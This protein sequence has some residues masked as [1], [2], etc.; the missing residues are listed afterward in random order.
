MAPKRK[1]QKTA[2]NRWANSGGFVRDEGRALSVANN[3]EEIQEAD[4]NE[5]VIP[6]SDIEEGA[7]N[8][9]VEEIGFEDEV[10]LRDNAQNHM[11]ALTVLLQHA[12]TA[13]THAKTELGPGKA[14]YRG[15]SRTS[16]YRQARR[17]QELAESVKDCKPLLNFF[18]KPP[19]PDPP[20]TI[21][22]SSDD[23]SDE[24]EERNTEVS[25]SI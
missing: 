23:E 15:T 18:K 4:V 20:V 12:V 6:L 2:L 10:E 7:P 9:E 16:L 13:Q 5:Y 1:R 17:A 22:I 14:A 8:E 21:S 11:D 19:P 3:E 25:S 24:L